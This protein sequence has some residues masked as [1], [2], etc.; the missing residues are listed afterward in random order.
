M[1]ELASTAATATSD[2][3]PLPQWDLSDLYPGRDSTELKTALADSESESKKFR[4]RYEGK[5]AS[6]SGSALAEAI[7]SF[8]HIQE[9]LGR[10]MSYAYLDYCTD[11]TDAETGRFFQNMQEKVNAI[12]TELLFFTLELNRIEDADLNAKLKD[13]GLAHYG[14]WLRDDARLPALSA[15]RRDRET[16]A[17]EIGRRPLGL[18]TAVRRDHGGAALPDRRQGPVERRGAASSLRAR[19]RVAQGSG[20]NRSARCSARMR[21]SSP[22]SPTRSRKT[23][24]SRIAGAASSGRSRR[25]TSAILSRTRSS[26]R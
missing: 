2:L 8:E 24:R 10:I 18:D 11:M 20:A 26:T 12:S 13:P 22:S 15:Q 14:P 25:A 7:R 23:R 5:L 17:R 6:L 21:A 16:A 3:G 1:A 9:T 19:C 4:T